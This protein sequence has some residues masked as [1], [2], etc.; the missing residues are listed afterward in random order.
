[1]RNLLKTGMLVDKHV[2]LVPIHP[3]IHKQARSHLSAGDLS[4]FLRLWISVSNDEIV[5]HHAFWNRG[6]AP[7]RDSS[8]EDKRSSHGTGALLTSSI[9]ATD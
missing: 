4:P 8:Q 2:E 9:D 3:D 7:T 1:M 6:D 5:P